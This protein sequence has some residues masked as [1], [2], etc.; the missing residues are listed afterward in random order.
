MVNVLDIT[1]LVT[2]GIGNFKRGDDEIPIDI[3]IKRE[4]KRFR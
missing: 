3:T 4:V 1:N 2:V